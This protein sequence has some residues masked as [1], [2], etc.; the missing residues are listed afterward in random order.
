MKNIRRIYFLRRAFGVGFCLFF[1]AGI[2]PVCAQYDNGD[3][4]VED[5]T[6][7]IA[8]RKV[9]TGPTYQM[10]EVSGQILDAATHKP[11]SGAHV[12]ALNDMRYT[13]MTEEDGRYTISVPVFVT[14]LFVSTPEYN[15]V[16]VPI[17]EGPLDVNLYSSV[18]KP[19][20]HNGTDVFRN[21]SMSVDNS[22]AISVESD[23][24]NQLNG[25]ART[26]MRGGM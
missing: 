5:T 15:P 8:K 10:K 25:S 12:E 26:M 14:A 11:I 18:F 17:K 3:S 22:S 23:I 2:S 20:Y 19:F 16:Q 13:A 6:V 7:L 24:E 4:T 21:H 9:P 1:I